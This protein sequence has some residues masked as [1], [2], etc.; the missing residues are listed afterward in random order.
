MTD[1]DN[2]IA[3]L[4]TSY[5]GFEISFNEQ[6][7][8]YVCMYVKALLSDYDMEDILDILIFKHGDTLVRPLN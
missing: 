2:L 1:D 4:E 5:E 6:V 7:Q 3:Q 8:R